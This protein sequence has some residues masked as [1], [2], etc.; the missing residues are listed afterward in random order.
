ME[1]DFYYLKKNKDNAYILNIMTYILDKIFIEKIIPVYMVLKGVEDT[2]LQSPSFLLYLLPLVFSLTS[3]LRDLSIN[4][5]ISLCSSN[6]SIPK[7]I[8]LLPY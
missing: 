8:V 5:H 4:V 6:A 2:V 1:P 7:F 3:C